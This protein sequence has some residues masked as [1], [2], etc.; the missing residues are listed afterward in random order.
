MSTLTEI[1]LLMDLE[2][3]IIFSD[4]ELIYHYSSKYDQ[5]I[6]NLI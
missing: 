2:D 6:D 1:H 4:S 5:K 3:E